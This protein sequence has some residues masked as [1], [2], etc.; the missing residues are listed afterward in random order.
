ME[1]N[2]STKRLKSE[3]NCSNNSINWALKNDSSNNHDGHESTSSDV[4]FQELYNQ[5][6]FIK[7]SINK[8]IW[9]NISMIKKFY[10]RDCYKTKIEFLKKNIQIHYKPFKV[11]HI[12][13][14]ISDTS[15][16]LS[17]IYNILKLG[18]Y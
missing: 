18:K 17:V 8:E 7:P 10:Q 3:D 15:Y 4:Y 5:F 12:N 1:N 16:L 14:L 11:V 2:Y 6:K 9:I 13:N